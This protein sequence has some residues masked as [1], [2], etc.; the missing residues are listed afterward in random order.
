MYKPV[1]YPPQPNG[2][3]LV[4]RFTK[5][6]LLIFGNFKIAL[7]FWGKRTSSHHQP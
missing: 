3:K 2:I 4:S 1:D 6:S 7:Q 5:R